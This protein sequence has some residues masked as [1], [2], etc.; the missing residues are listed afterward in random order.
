MND[1]DE[2]TEAAVDW[3]LQSD[4]PAVRLM[5]RRDLLA[6]QVTADPV[7]I[8]AGPRVT[9]LLAG[10][11]ADGGFGV[12]YYSKWTGAHWRLVSL[13]ELEVPA[14]EPRAIAAVGTVLEA[15]TPGRRR[16]TMRNG[17][18]LTHASVWGNALAVASRL[19]LA[20]DQQVQDIASAIVSWQ[21]PDG[22][23]NCDARATGYR[24]SFHESL[25][26]MWGLHEYSRATGDATAAAAAERAAELFLQHRLFR[27]LATGEVINTRWLALRY[28]PY[29]H[30]D[31][32]QALLVLSRMGKASDPRAAEALDEVE[33]QRLPDGRWRPAGSWWTG[34][35]ARTAAEV[36]N[37]G[38]TG[39]N[40]MITLNA[41]RV[42][43]S[44]GRCG[45]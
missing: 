44:A 27:S 37:W 30:Y 10:Q 7:E 43:R 28:P 19:G 32:L 23:W 4:E 39:P 34:V 5:A 24:S 26:T 6:E 14:G 9:A 13:V 33:R 8:L 45:P 2:P 3:L 18:P 16:P 25:S 42:L 40:E 12:G 38:R 22:G 41:L 17:L 35:G 15:L 31:I 11:Q 20:A 36:V 21:W 29:W 1:V